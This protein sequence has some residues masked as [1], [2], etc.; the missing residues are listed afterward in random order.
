MILQKVWSHFWCKPCGWDDENCPF[1]V[2][3]DNGNIGQNRQKLV[4]LYCFSQKSAISTLQHSILGWLDHLIPKYGPLGSFWPNFEKTLNRYKQTQ[5]FKKL[6]FF[7]FDQLRFIN[8]FPESGHSYICEFLFRI[9][10]IYSNIWPYGHSVQCR[11]YRLC[12]P[13]NNIL[14][15]NHISVTLSVRK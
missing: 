7:L 10:W 8:S 1:Q 15:R 6:K 13:R 11:G 4:N 9:Y 14:Y 5:K 3:T 12:I 2:F